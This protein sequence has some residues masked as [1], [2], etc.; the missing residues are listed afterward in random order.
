[1]AEIAEPNDANMNMQSNFSLKILKLKL[2]EDF[3][4]CLKN[5]YCIYFCMLFWLFFW[6][7]NYNLRILTGNWTI[8]AS[9]HV[10]D[11]ECHR[12]LSI[13]I[14][15]YMNC[16][17]VIVYSGRFLMWKPHYSVKFVLFAAHTKFFIHYRIIIWC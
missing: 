8:S 6:L 16:D 7:Y 3:L 13:I 5:L 17:L 14:S 10:L 4:S 12:L 9:K 1:M 2:I 11:E 15:H